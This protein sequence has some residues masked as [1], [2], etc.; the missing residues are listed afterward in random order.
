MGLFGDLLSSA[1]K[2]ALETVKAEKERNNSSTYD[3][4][5][6]SKAHEAYKKMS[7]EDKKIVKE[8]SMYAKNWED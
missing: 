7:P 4:S 6:I 5:I 3:N 2:S 1:K 8:N